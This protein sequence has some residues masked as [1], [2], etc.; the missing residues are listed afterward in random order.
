MRYCLYQKA[1]L[2][3][4]SMYELLILMRESLM[5]FYLC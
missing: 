5:E 4:L 3:L 2:I 1:L